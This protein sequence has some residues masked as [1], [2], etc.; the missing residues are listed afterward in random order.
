M[1]ADARECLRKSIESDLQKQLKITGQTASYQT[2]LL[3][4]YLLLWD[5]KNKLLDDIRSI[6]IK[7]SG[8]HGPKSNP[9][10]GDLHKT[11]E[12][13][14]KILDALNLNVPNAEGDKGQNGVESD[15]I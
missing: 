10:I 1:D 7:V 4:D 6:G 9:A 12:R 8:M 15:L 5:L 14:L 13:M 11:N 3:N 2:D